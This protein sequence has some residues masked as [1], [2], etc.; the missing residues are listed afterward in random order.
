MKIQPKKNFQEDKNLKIF[1]DNY[2]LQTFN[3]DKRKKISVEK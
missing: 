3:E 1:Q 2:W